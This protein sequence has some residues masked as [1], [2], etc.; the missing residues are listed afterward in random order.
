MFP[1]TN[2]KTKAMDSLSF[3][4]KHYSKMLMVYYES[5]NAQED[6]VLEGLGREVF[7]G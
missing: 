4:L 2:P 7:S 6:S 1:D 5:I 3:V